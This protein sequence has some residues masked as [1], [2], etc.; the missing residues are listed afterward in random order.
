MG[1]A[2]LGALLADF[3][4][5]IRRVARVYY[6]QNPIYWDHFCRILKS[7]VKPEN[8][9]NWHT[10]SS[11]YNTEIRQKRDARDHL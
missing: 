6:Y 3:A 7:L 8:T 11:T 1:L 5:R 9:A 10:Y 2:E 4:L